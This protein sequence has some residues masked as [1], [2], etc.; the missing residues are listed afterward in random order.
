[1]SWLY[2][3]ERKIGRFAIPNLMLVIV[4]GML[5][6]FAADFV[7]PAL[8][9]SGYLSLDWHMV[10]QGQVW[11][12]I[13]FIFLPPSS[14][15]LWIF[16]TLYFNYLIGHTLE[17]TWGDFKFNVYYFCGVV[18]NIIAAMLTGYGM[19]SYLNLSLFFAFAVLYPDFQVMLFF[20]LPVK[21][22]YLALIDA[23]YFVLM[24]IVGD[25]A[26]RAAILLSL[27]NFILFF[28][29]DFIRMIRQQAGYQKTR[30]NFRKYMK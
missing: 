3:L 1:M 16:I 20:I 13:T 11:R 26:T 17:N 14:S 2:K 22:K 6:V 7:I 24:L 28:G 29:G 27:V 30:R 23:A 8:N 21:I 19:N 5:T 25:W 15:V 18:G 9:L 4:T 12:L 10:M